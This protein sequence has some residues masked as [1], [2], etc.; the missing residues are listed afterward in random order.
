MSNKLPVL[1]IIVRKELA[2]MTP[3]RVAAMASHATS[4]ME[5][6]HNLLVSQTEIASPVYEEWVDETT[7]GY[8]TAI[9]LQHMNW[10]EF[11]ENIFA[12]VEALCSLS[13]EGSMCGIVED[14][15]YAVKDGLVTHYLPVETCAYVLTYKGSKI[16]NTFLNLKMYDGK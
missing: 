9:I 3:G 2:S 10:D 16:A 7:Q 12:E 11:K 5:H 14:P 13:P 4:L 8:G 15:T 1:Y 6:N